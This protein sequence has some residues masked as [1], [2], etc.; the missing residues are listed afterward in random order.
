[1][2]K[3]GPVRSRLSDALRV[4][5]APSGELSGLRA[6]SLREGS[7]VIS[8][9]GAARAVRPG[10]RIGAATVKAVGSDRIILERPQPLAQAPAAVTNGA[11]IMVV[12]F[13]PGGE[14]RVRTYASMGAVAPLPE[15]R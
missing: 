7:A 2:A 1:V 14:A 9:A 8:L 5:E 11:V 12:T 6:V 3:A 15:R 10:D 13:G 4:P